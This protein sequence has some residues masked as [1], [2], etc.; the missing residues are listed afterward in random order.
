[1]KL[2]PFE[3]EYLQVGTSLPFDLHNT[4]GLLLMPR[5]AVIA[6]RT[7]LEHL[8]GHDLM[9]DEHQSAEWRQERARE[10]EL[11]DAFAEAFE[12]PRAAAPPP[13]S[14]PDH[15]ELIAELGQLQSQLH[16]LLIDNRPDDKWLPR[17][18]AVS[19]RTL[20][21][22]HQHA[23]ALLFLVLQRAVRRYEHY[24]SRHSLLCAMASALCAE[25][26]DMPEAQVRSLMLAALTMNWSMTAM[27][28]ELTLRER[29]PSL[30]Q[31]V[32]IDR[33]PELSAR[34]LES[35][36]VQDRLCIDVVTR[37]HQDGPVDLRFAALAPADQLARVLRRLDV[38]FA[39]ISP[40]LSRPGMPAP[41][42]ARA[43]CLGPNGEPDEVG[44]AIIK[45]LGI[46]PPGTC[47]ALA[48]GELAMVLRRGPHASQPHVVSL[49][50]A[51]GAALLAPLRRDTAQPAYRITG[52]VRPSDLRSAV[53]LP[54]LL[55]MM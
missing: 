13:P 29:T 50:T 8:L 17:M 12:A 52:T 1:M 16:A 36:G 49:T 42:A 9:V 24:S 10:R 38:F 45:V 41:L 40:R 30:D 48:N 31:R 5:E 22:T 23:D 11:E 43:A 51:G 2:I 7:Q 33:H 35:A 54:D 28:D 6:D 37:H 4:E 44:S 20:D 53:A 32:R 14:P 34:Q 55:A 3:A 46:Y 19:S 39:K 25:Q 47:V 21:L 18:V 26:L 27:Q 15:A